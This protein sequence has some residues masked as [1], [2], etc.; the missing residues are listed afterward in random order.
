MRDPLAVVTRQIPNHFRSAK[1]VADEND[2]L[3]IECV[4]DRSYVIS[5]SVEI[6]TAAGIIGTCMTATVEGDATP[7]APFDKVN[8]RDVPPVRAKP[9]WRHEDDR[10]ASA[11]IS[12]MKPSPIAR[13]DHGRQWSCATRFFGCGREA[14]A[15]KR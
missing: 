3:Q 7:A 6:V 4:Q 5:E 15:R 2:I 12:K 13:V 10:S 9:P 14:S 11:P 1:G 8:Y